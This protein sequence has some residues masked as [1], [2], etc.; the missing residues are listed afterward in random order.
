M[1]KKVRVKPGKGQSMMGFI[2]GILFC[3]IGVF[4]VIPSAG[5]FGVFWTLM[6]LIITITN[7]MNAFTDKGVATHEIVIDEGRQT[8]DRVAD[9][10]TADISSNIISDMSGTASDRSEA[11]AKGIKGNIELR[12]QVAEDLYKA[13]TITKEE[14]EAKRREI[15]DEL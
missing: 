11:V 14:Y 12:L 4:V 7:A 15:L 9:G 2:V 13:G 5:L 6:A 3:L 1:S 10:T 8:E